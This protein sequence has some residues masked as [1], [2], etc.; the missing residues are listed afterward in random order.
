LPGDT[1]EWMWGPGRDRHKWFQYGCV[2]DRELLKPRA[3]G[4]WRPGIR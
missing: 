2:V 4:R 3:P 1:S